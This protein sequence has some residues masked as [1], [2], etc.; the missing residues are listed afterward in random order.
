MSKLSK[1]KNDSGDDDDGNS[2]KNDKGPAVTEPLIEGEA[3]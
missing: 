3:T 1:A 2:D